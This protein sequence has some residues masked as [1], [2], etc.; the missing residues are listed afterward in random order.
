[1][2]QVEKNMAS[3]T[4]PPDF[5]E[6]VAL[7]AETDGLLKDYITSI[8]ISRITAGMSDNGFMSVNSNHV[9]AAMILKRMEPCTLK[10][11]AAMLRL[12]K[13]SASALVDR[14]MENGIIRREANPENRREVLLSIDPA[15]ENFEALLRDKLT[16]WFAGLVSEMGTETFEKWHDVM[17]SLN[18]I[19]QEK[20]R[21]SHG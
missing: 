20:I 11:F 5:S 17:L 1:M 14:M 8:V 13:S 16:Q 3:G 21:K 4:L 7:I 15:F 12:S 9:H 2:K 19:I 18:K 10:D 6:K